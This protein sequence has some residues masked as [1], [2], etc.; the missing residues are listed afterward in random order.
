MIDF[1]LGIVFGLF[2]CYMIMKLIVNYTLRQMKQSGV[3]ID[4]LI[5]TSTKSNPK[6]LLE[7]KVEEINGIF[8]AWR[9]Q[10]NRF[11]AQA[12][13]IDELSTHVFGK[14]KGHEVIVFTGDKNIIEKLQ[15]LKDRHANA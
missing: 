11:V 4:G 9:D 7:I 14:F 6:T 10:D 13:T 1:A 5:Y 3:D 12:V 8:Y 15:N 2:L